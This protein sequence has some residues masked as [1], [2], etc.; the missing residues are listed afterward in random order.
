M[1]GTFTDGTMDMDKVD[2][3]MCESNGVS[4]D[5]VEDVLPSVGDNQEEE[6]GQEGKKTT[7]DQSSP[8]PPPPLHSA[9]HI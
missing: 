1:N 3:K 9:R 2:T 7:S 4:S 6:C 8:P 5:L